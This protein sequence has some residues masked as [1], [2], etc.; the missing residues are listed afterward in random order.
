M[1]PN[2]TVSIS[3]ITTTFEAG[4]SRIT[5][6]VNGTLLWFESWNTLLHLVPE[7]EA[8]ARAFLL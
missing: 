7:A 5:A 6:D 2:P 4:L 1:S 8:F 3:Q